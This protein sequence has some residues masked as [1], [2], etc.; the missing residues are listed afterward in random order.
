MALLLKLVPVIAGVSYESAAAAI[1]KL[2]SAQIAAGLAGAASSA[3]AFQWP[4]CATGLLAT[5]QVCN[6]SLAPAE[7]AAALVAALTIAE[8]T[9]NL[10]K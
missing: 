3:S 8:K 2:T 7:R 1:M 10:V 9:A 4:N 6:T 5:N